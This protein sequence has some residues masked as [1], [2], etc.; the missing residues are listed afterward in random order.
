MEHFLLLHFLAATLMAIKATSLKWVIIPNVDK[1]PHAQDLG[2]FAVDVYNQ[3]SH[4]YLKFLQVVEGEEL[5]RGS[6]H[7]TYRLAIKVLDDTETR[8]YWSEV[9]QDLSAPSQPPVLNLG[10][11][12]S[13][14]HLPWLPTWSDIPDAANDER[15]H[16]LA[17][18]AVEIYSTQNHAVLKLLQV[19]D[20]QCSRRIWFPDEFHSQCQGKC[21]AIGKNTNR[22]D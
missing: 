20:G 18:F 7:Y 6:E 12:A 11:F 3:Q 8:L 21:S 22:K 13:V 5:D 15:L 16:H 19:V 2:A 9:L 17:L 14:P 10:S 1:D 4:A